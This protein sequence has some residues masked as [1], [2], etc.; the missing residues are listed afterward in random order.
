MLWTHMDL[1]HRVGMWEEG[2]EERGRK[3]R[4]SEGG[5][6]PGG[7]KPALGQQGAS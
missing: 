3:G 1:G 7:D 5:P 6:L 4:G 2:D